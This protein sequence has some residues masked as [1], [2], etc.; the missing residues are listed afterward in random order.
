MEAG[1]LQATHLEVL[2]RDGL[3]RTLRQL[4]VAEDGPANDAIND[5]SNPGHDFG[6]SF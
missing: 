5:V 2:V 6:G 1:A 3:I 4:D